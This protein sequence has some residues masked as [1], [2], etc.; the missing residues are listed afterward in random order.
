[1]RQPLGIAIVVLAHLSAILLPLYN[2]AGVYLYSIAYPRRGQ[3]GA[4][5]RWYAHLLATNRAN[6]TLKRKIT[7]LELIDS[8]D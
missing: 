2:D 3:R 7:E 1:L 4:G 6:T 5:N 8:N